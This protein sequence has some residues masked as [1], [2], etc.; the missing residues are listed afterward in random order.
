MNYRLL[1][2]AVIIVAGISLG[3]VWWNPFYQPLVAQLVID[4]V[5]WGLQGDY[6]TMSIPIRN[7]GENPVTIMSI[8]VRED[9]V[10][11]TEYTDNDP[12][13]VASGSNDIAGGGGDTFEWNAGSGSAPITFLQSG[14]TYVIKVTTGT[15][16]FEKT[17][18]APAEMW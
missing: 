7:V 2:L 16:I 4:E 13:G 17:V 5:E 3:V 8:S 6:T 14:K 12:I 1:T 9:V 11:S 15:G 10:V 18:T